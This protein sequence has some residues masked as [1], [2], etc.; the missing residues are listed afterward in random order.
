MDGWIKEPPISLAWD[1]H[2]ISFVGLDL[3]RPVT[4]TQPTII[5]PTL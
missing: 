4:V 3:Y 2:C 1:L 5:K